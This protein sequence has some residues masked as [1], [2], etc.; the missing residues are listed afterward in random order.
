MATAI[1]IIHE[2]Y[3]K[4]TVRPVKIK[5]TLNPSD[6]GTKRLPG[7]SHHRHFR[8]MR[9]QRFYPAPTSLHGELMQVSLVVQRHTEFDS[10]IKTK[11][12]FE[13]MRNKMAVYDGKE[14]NEYKV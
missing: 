13:E 11:I 14:T 1:A 3:K 5:G 2:E 7:T 9:G 6:M 12:N 4:G 8:Q 10:E